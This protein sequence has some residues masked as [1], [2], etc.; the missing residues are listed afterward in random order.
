MHGDRRPSMINLRVW[1]VESLM[2]LDCIMIKRGPLRCLWKDEM[3]YWA[4]SR[5]ESAFQSVNWGLFHLIILLIIF[6]LVFSF[7]LWYIFS[8]FFLGKFIG[9]LV[10]NRLGYHPRRWSRETCW[11]RKLTSLNIYWE[12]WL[13]FFLFFI[14]TIHGYS[15][16]HEQVIWLKGVFSCVKDQIKG[17]CVCNRTNSVI[18][19]CFLFCF[20]YFFF[21]KNVSFRKE[22]KILCGEQC[23][24]LLL[25]RD[26]DIKLPLYVLLWKLA[27]NKKKQANKICFGEMIHDNS[28]LKNKRDH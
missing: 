8:I 17:W 23:S 1:R 13:N 27:W 24:C 20:S 15:K 6:G 14:F 25:I 9:I 4:K 10:E 2:V 18:F 26:K 22:R 5:T 16:C 28:K 19:V 12:A 21:R 11:V 7:K 3:C